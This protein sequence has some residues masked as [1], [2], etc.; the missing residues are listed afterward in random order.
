MFVNTTDN[1]TNSLQEHLVE[2][3]P[4]EDFNVTTRLPERTCDIC[5]KLFMCLGFSTGCIGLVLS[6]C[7]LIDYYNI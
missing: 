1:H 6:A 7:K 3:G 2:I 5:I 4:L